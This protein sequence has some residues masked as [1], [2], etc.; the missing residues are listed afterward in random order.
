MRHILTAHFF[1]ECVANCSESKANKNLCC[2]NKNTKNIKNVRNYNIYWL[3]QNN[4]QFTTNHKH[5]AYSMH[6]CNL[7]LSPYVCGAH[8]EGRD[9]CY[10]GPPLT[11]GWLTPSLP[12]LSTAHEWLSYHRHS[13]TPIIIISHEQWRLSSSLTRNVSQQ[14]HFA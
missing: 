14:A 2:E 8:R 3:V 6:I 5:S 11:A 7:A 1:V 13:A 4:K 10:G 9:E 12:F